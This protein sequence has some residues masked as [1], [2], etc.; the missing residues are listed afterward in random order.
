MKVTNELNSKITR[1]V[2][3]KYRDEIE[4][5]NNAIK[6]LKEEAIKK[7]SE[8]IDRATEVCPILITALS[9]GYYTSK[10]SIDISRRWVNTKDLVK[11]NDIDEIEKK[12]KE[13]SDKKS[14]EIENIRI[15][16]SYGK[17]FEDIKSV[18]N[19]YG[20]DF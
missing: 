17:S 20:V 10:T 13:I 12:L 14:M 6:Q 7:L 8:E 5:L 16:I 18:F 9:Q 1:C 19:E 15:K 2:N 3:E 4:S 11:I